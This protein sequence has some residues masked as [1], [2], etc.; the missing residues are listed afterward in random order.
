MKVRFNKFEKVAGLFVLIA[1]L[2]CGLGMLAIAAKNGWFSR[3]VSYA[4]ELESAD[5]VH[6]GSVV[7][8]A[9][10][11]VGSVSRVELMGDDRVRVEFSILER[12]RDKVRISSHVTMFRPFVLAEKV[13][14]ISSGTAD[15]AEMPPGSV[16]PSHPTTDIMDLLSGKKMSSVLG[17]FDRLADSLRIVGEAFASP[18]RSRAMVKMFDQMGPLVGN[19]N[20]MSV[21]IVKLTAAMNKKQR[22]DVIF[23]NLA[24]ISVEME[25]IIPAFNEQVPD[26]GA[27]LAQ[28]VRNLNVLTTEFQKLT[29]AI[30]TL[31]PELPRTTRRA[32][33]ALDETVVLLKAMQKSFFFRSKVEEVRGEEGR[34]P[35]STGRGGSGGSSGEK[36][37]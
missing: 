18:E 15:E 37:P 29:P 19:L 6:A 34:Q 4:T 31:A 9:G 16:I 5:G 24:R 12:F 14:E 2:G 26:V 3:K 17:S 33:E 23:E 13:L 25:K 36:E 27:Q 10:L 30:A 1:F 21:Q 28:I 8:I 11:R 32:V 7:Q 20:A 22:A 35:A